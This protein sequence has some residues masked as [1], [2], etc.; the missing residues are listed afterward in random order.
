M[1]KS[2]FKLAIA[3]CCS[4][5]ALQWICCLIAFTSGCIPCLFCICVLLLFLLAFHNPK[6]A[7][8]LPTCCPAIACCSLMQKWLC[9]S[10][11]DK[12]WLMQMVAA[13]P[14]CHTQHG[15][16]DCQKMAWLHSLDHVGKMGYHHS[17]QGALS[18]YGRS[19]TP[20]SRSTSY[21]Q[22]GCFF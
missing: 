8:L 4:F 2:M 12:G 10:D 1:H 14:S 5:A 6:P 18:G 7:S 22:S 19:S 16:S 15:C 13:R 21:K 20:F 9:T 17:T 3:R 11:F